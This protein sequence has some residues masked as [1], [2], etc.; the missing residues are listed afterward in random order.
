MFGPCQLETSPA[1]MAFNGYC[2]DCCA[3][4]F[5]SLRDAEN[6]IPHSL[7]VFLEI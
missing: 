7:E 4:V 5:L 6:I 3:S 2:S 1:S